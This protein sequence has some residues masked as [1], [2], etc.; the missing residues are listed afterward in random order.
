MLNF[1]ATLAKKIAKT[2]TESLLLAVK[3]TS[4]SQ[5]IAAPLFTTFLDV[6]P[7]YIENATEL[8]DGFGKVV[9][10]SVKSLHKSS[11]EQTLG[12]MASVS[13]DADIKNNPKVSKVKI[14]GEG[15]YLLE[16]FVAQ[17]VDNYFVKCSLDFHMQNLDP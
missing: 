3:S 5:E 10:A 1:S 14:R 16:S 9:R 11:I 12:W 2:A 13:T 17:I 15:R 4:L 8:F 6:D 7:A